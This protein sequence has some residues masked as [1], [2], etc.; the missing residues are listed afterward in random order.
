MFVRMRRTFAY[1]QENG[2]RRTIPAGWAGNLEDSIAQRAVDGGYTSEPASEKPASLTGQTV[3]DPARPAV[4]GDQTGADGQVGEVNE[5]MTRAELEEMAG[6][7]GI[8]P[9][10]HR[11]KADLVAAINGA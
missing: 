11:T 10:D 2:T 9:E 3:E 1:D 5:N 8:D 7:R 4:T 6:A